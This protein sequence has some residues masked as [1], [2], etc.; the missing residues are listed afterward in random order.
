MWKDQKGGDLEN[1]CRPQEPITL[2]KFAITGR[3]AA[4]VLERIA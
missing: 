4:K 3:L 1:T 2:S